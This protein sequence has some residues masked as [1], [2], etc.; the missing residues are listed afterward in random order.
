MSPQIKYE[1][2]AAHHAQKNAII[3]YHVDGR[4]MKYQAVFPLEGKAYIITVNLDTMVETKKEI[5]GVSLKHIMKPY[6]GQ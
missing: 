1:K 6:K 5:R 2:K 4:E 3:E